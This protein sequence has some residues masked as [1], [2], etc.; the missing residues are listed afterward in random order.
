MVGLLLC[1][2]CCVFRLIIMFTCK[3]LF[4]CQS[5]VQSISAEGT[6][7][8]HTHPTNKQNMTLR[9]LLVSLAKLKIDAP[10]SKRKPSSSGHFGERSDSAQM[11]V[12]LIALS[13][14]LLTKDADVL[15]TVATSAHGA[16][17]VRQLMAATL[18]LTVLATAGSDGDA[19]AS[20][21]LNLGNVATL[22]N[23]T[24]STLARQASYEAL[25]GLPDRVTWNDARAVYA[26]L[27]DALAH[28]R[29]LPAGAAVESLLMSNATGSDASP[30]AVIDTFI[31]AVEER[32]SHRLRTAPRLGVVSYS[33][34]LATSSTL[35]TPPPAPSP[36]PAAAVPPLPLPPPTAFRIEPTTSLTSNL[37]R[38]IEGHLH[39]SASDDR[40]AIAA[41]LDEGL[42]LLLPAATAAR[43][44]ELLATNVLTA[45]TQPSTSW[46]WASTLEAT[47]SDRVSR[48][49]DMAT[50][51][52]NSC[53]A[54]AA[55]LF[56]EAELHAALG[57]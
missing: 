11:P 51:I 4:A 42:S 32:A 47:S 40:T 52:L 35:P 13:R 36:V 26:A 3:R 37:M 45:L 20:T 15:S 27:L 41:A 38:L 21:P 10:T 57:L 50:S 6:T 33:S 22:F 48:V 5:L 7:R 49:D 56:A 19:A 17:L 31:V 29:T 54:T 12:R 39:Q 28:A 18:R 55:S 53:S 2:G 8:T 46:L 24:G 14:V 44:Q 34:S 23:V 9:P 25:F 30:A 16:E 1:M 43:R